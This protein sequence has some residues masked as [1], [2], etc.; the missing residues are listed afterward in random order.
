MDLPPPW[1]VIAPLGPG[2][3]AVSYI[4]VLSPDRDR[5]DVIELWASKAVLVNMR[6]L[7][8]NGSLHSRLTRWCPHFHPLQEPIWFA[9]FIEFNS[10]N[11]DWD[12]SLSCGN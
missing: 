3:F 10:G 1:E 6:A 11:Y 4:D 2:P 9:D 7:R 5:K 8:L 12:N